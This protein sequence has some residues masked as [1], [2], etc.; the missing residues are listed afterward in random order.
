MI[1]AT[2]IILSIL[3]VIPRMENP[4]YEDLDTIHDTLH[5]LCNGL[6]REETSISAQ[7]SFARVLAGAVVKS[8]GTHWHRLT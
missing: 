2:N 3:E 6:D 8:A 4:T 5:T 7:G 1:A